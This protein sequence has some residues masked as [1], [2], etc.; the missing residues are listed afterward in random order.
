MSQQKRFYQFELLRSKTYNN[1]NYSNG[2]LV[3]I[4]KNPIEDSSQQEHVLGVVDK[5][6]SELL[7][8]RVVLTQSDLR[9]I[10]VAKVLM[11]NSEWNGK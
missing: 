11:K 9:S 5:F 7:V 8:V 10:A 3:F 6:S 2:D 1:I 4:S